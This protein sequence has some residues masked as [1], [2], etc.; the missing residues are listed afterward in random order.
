MLLPNPQNM[1]HPMHR[2]EQSKSSDIYRTHR[3]LS[4]RA[5]GLT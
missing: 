5:T 2:H 4:Y 3:L 1:C